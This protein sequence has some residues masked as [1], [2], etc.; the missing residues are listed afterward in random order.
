VEREN[1]VTKELRV[2]MD[3]KETKVLQVLE[4]TKV[5]KV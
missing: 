3:H 1:P 4:G 5:R 2:Q